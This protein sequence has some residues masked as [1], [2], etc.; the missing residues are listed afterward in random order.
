MNKL[1]YY[2]KTVRKD[3]K[4]LLLA[5]ILVYF[6]IEIILK[7]YNEVFFGASKLGDFFSKLSVSYISAFIFYFIVVHIK[8]QK[9]KDNINEFVGYEIFQ[10]IIN[11]HLLISPLEKDLDKGGEFEYLDK[12]KLFDLLASVDRTANES[13]LILNGSKT[14]WNKWFE[15]LKNNTEKSINKIMG[16]Y[17]HLDSELIKL[18]TRLENSLFFNQFEML[19]TITHDKTFKFFQIEVMTYLNLT[20]ELEKYALKHFG[21]HRF[22]TSEFHGWR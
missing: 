12:K 19:F 18:L 5:A 10:I 2:F 20:Q 4:V 14:N 21:N 3:L 7:R 1:F 9:D 13:P 16:R 8:N 15:Y 11:G 6:I 17:T 22:N